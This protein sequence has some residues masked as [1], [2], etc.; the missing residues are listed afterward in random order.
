[1]QRSLIM[2]TSSSVYGDIENIPLSAGIADVV[3]SNCVLNLV[4]DKNQAFY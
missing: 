2:K 1:M 3:V 4:P